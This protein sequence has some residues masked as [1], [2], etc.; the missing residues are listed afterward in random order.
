MLKSS[1]I[2][3]GLTLVSRFLG[4]ARDL[5]LTARL[6]ASQTLA[7]DAFYTALTFPNLF[8]RMFAEGAFA[9]S[10]VPDY[11][12]RLAADGKEAADA[13]AADAL[14]TMA[15]LT[16]AITVVCQL[17]MPW[18][19]YLYS[20][21]YGPGSDKFKLAVIL[22]QITMPYLPCMV[23]AALFAGTLQARGRFIVY[24]LYPTLLNVV[25]LVAVLP[26]KDPTGAAY[27]ASW[28]VVVAGVS[29]AALCWWGARRAGAHIH[30]RHLRL[31][32]DIKALLRRMV[33][34]VIA[35]SATQIN[36]FI[37]AALASQVA[38]MRVWLNVAERFYQLP[39]SLVGVAI[40]VALLPRLS[41]AVQLKDK[42]DTQGSLDQ[43]VVFGLALTLP[44]AAALMGMPGYLVDGLFAR[45]NFTSQD[46]ANSAAL[47]FHY[48]W[49]VPAFVLIKILQPAFFARG[50][51]RTPM[52]YSLISVGVNIAL[53]VLLFYTVGFPGIAIA[54]A[55]ASWIT[56]LQMGL[57]LSRTEV[58][59]PSARAW[60]KIVRVAAASVL[61][62]ALVATGSHYRALLEAPL[63][64]LPGAKE[65]VVLAVALAGALAYPVLLFALGGVTPA[66]AKTA[67]RRRR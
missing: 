51:T 10:F 67:L 49:G 14:A 33:P 31:N 54:T 64:G 28:G 1:A 46:A 58:W 23:I 18:I 47:L 34:G 35:S 6:G 66:E 43:A 15:A 19:M 44:A 60:G 13:F 32:A 3:S 41:K 16:I 62:G 53:G 17:A 12:K 4:L 37:S 20:N 57:K 22:T 26:Q 27:A 59:R 29:Q 55:A 30:P 7:A 25:M 48:G 65:I 36:L 42:E 5:V 9:A 45:G 21:G 40:G 39:L 52:V 61:M 38:G 11:S 8:R 56:V 50:D 24:G 63:A 2:Y